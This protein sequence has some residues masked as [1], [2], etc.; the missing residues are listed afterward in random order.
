M[1]PPLDPWTT[2]SP[3]Q[4]AARFGFKA[5]AV[6]EAVRRGDVECTRLERDR[7]AFTLEQALAVRSF[8]LGES[9]SAC[10]SPD[11]GATRPGG[12][13]PGA[14]GAEAVASPPPPTAGELDSASTEHTLLAMQRLRSRLAS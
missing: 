14:G 8:L 1:T 3:E 11:A 2:H 13:V 5:N 4:V 10:E 9:V 7:M 12:G 6:R